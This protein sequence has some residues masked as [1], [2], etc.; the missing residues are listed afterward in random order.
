MQEVTLYARGYCKCFEEYKPGSWKTLTV[1]NGVEKVMEGEALNTTS[2][3]MIIQGLIETVKDLEEPSNIK[4]VTYIPIGVKLARKGKGVNKNLLQQL[5]EL[6]DLGGHQAT[7]TIENGQTGTSVWRP[8]R[9][10]EQPV[11]KEATIKKNDKTVSIYV[12]GSCQYQSKEREGAWV[13]LL[14]FK[15]REKAI[16]GESKNT[17]DKQMVIIGV[18]EAVKCL[19]EPCHVNIYT[20]GP[21]GLKNYQ[22]GKGT[23]I[24][25]IKQMFEVLA[26]GNHSFEFIINN[27]RVLDLE[28]AL[29]MCKQKKQQ[30]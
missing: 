8:D 2:Y 11:V 1:I 4:I 6:I 10:E 30:S 23:N 14:C 18:T 19:K 12:K 28:N 7:F 3:R 17:T 26:E 16:Y 27:D 21:F 24:G 15:G 13:A 20:A 9:H 25:L 5:F 29:K 22:N